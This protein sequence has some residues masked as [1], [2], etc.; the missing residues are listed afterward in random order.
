MKKVQLKRNLFQYYDLKQKQYGGKRGIVGLQNLGNT[1]YM[2]SG[3][4]CL[5]NTK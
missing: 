2:N 1:C 3:L 5:S 4:Q